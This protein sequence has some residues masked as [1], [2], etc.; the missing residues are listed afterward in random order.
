MIS[1]EGSCASGIVCIHYPT[2]RASI[3]AASALRFDATTNEPFLPFPVDSP[4]AEYRLTPPRLSDVHD[5]VT[6]VNSP[7]IQPWLASTPVPAT[8]TW[9]QNRIIVEQKRALETLLA[10]DPMSTSA[11][12]WARGLPVG[13]IRKRVEGGEDVYAGDLGIG[14][15]AYFL[16]AEGEEERRRWSDENARRE[17]GDPEIV[18]RVGFYIIDA[19]A[20]RGLITAAFTLARN[21][22]IESMNLRHMLT[23]AF[24]ANL[25]SRRVQIKTGFKEIGSG[26]LT[27]RPDRVALCGERTEVFVYEWRKEDGDS[28]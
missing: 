13:V 25:G 26:W 10:W 23:G 2:L 24:T 14:R 18:W 28:S 11:K 7:S 1:P 17:V 15:E 19:F 9:V 27:M 22:A 12:R 5:K 21:F 6:A 8:S 20:G 4:F 3:S 16:M